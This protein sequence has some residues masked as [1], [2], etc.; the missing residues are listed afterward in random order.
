MRAECQYFGGMGKMRCEI[1]TTQQEGTGI[2]DPLRS[3]S[4][5]GNKPDWLSLSSSPLLSFP[6]PRPS[7]GLSLG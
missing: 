3:T 5:S 7:S 6:F 2:L 1:P 4:F